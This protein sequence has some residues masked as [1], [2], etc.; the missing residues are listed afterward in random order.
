MK[1][2]GK[3]IFTVS[4]FCLGVA[5]SSL[6]MSA[7]E[8]QKG[9]EGFKGFQGEGHGSINIDRGR[10]DFAPVMTERKFGPGPSPNVVNINSGRHERR[11]IPSSSPS[12]VNVFEGR[13]GFVP[14]PARRF[15]PGTF[16]PATGGFIAGSDRS[17][18]GA[19]F[20]RH[21]YQPYYPRPDYYRYLARGRVL[22]SWGWRHLPSDL[23]GGL[24]A[25]YG[26]DYFWIGDYV[27]LVNVITG[28]IVDLFLISSLNNYNNYYNN[29]DSYYDDD[30]YDY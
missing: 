18:I 19:Y 4:V 27:V 21:H 2:Y 12:T 15:Q 16:T 8:G 25:P 1:K 24:Y 7:P 29:Y 30:E 11:F 22:P 6:T 10:R 20:G 23:L 5:L 14:P 13:R 9:H 26:Y 17:K 3:L 28:V